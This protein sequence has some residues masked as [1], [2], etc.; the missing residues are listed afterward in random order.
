MSRIFPDSAAGGPVLSQSVSLLHSH[1]DIKSNTFAFSEWRRRRNFL[2]TFLERRPRMAELLG[3][4]SKWSYVWVLGE[5]PAYGTSL[6]AA[7]RIRT[8]NK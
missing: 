5:V 1:I 7:I 4:F 3:R 2:V 8:G 6:L